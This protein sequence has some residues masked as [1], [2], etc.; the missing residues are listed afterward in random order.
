MTFQLHVMQ[1]PVPPVMRAITQRPHPLKATTILAQ[2]AIC[3]V[4]LKYMIQ[5]EMYFLFLLE[6][7]LTA[8]FLPSSTN[9]KFMQ[10]S[11]RK[12]IMSLFRPM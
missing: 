5:Y 7:Y 8:L 12:T 1:N 4:T 10:K 3:S 11:E 9:L 2:V 6:F